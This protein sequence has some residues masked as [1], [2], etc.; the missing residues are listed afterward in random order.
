MQQDRRPPTR[1]TALAAILGTSAWPFFA[2]RAEQARNTDAAWAALAGDGAVALVRHAKAPG[3]SPDPPGAS[4]AD[5]ATQR[6]LSPEGRAQAA[7]LGAL[8]RAKR[9]KIG[10]VVS[11]PW[12]R[13]LDTARL[14]GLGPPEVSHALYNLLANP[15]DRE[16]KVAALTKMMREWRG[17]GALVLVTHG[18]TIRRVAPRAGDPGEAGVVVVKPDLLLARGYAVVGT[19]PPPE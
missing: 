13:C 11:S 1:R 14:M 3:P 9:V 15:P 8:W 12:C 17:P 5:C 6:N 16:A 2:T 4:L 19:I 10:K 7:R 18:I